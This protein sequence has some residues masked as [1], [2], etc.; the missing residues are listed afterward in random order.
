MDGEIQHL[1]N[2]FLGLGYPRFT[3][4]KALSLAKKRYY[5]PK[6][7]LEKDSQKPLVLPYMPN[8][9]KIKCEKIGL[10]IAFQF[11]N[12]IRKQITH[13]KNEEDNIG[14]GVYMIP[15]L[16][17]DKCYIGE[18]GRGLKVRCEEHVRACANG[19]PNSA[20]AQHSINLDHRINFKD[21]KII[22]REACSSKR[23]IVEGAAIHSVETFENNKAF[24]DEDDILSKI[25]FDPISKHFRAAISVA[26]P[27]LSL[28][29][30]RGVIV[31][32]QHPDAGTDGEHPN[33][34]SREDEPPPLRRSARIRSLRNLP[35]D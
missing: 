3:I 11:K 13:N 20:I 35:G 19:N 26:D 30:A 5:C 29:Q 15:C 32:E 22:Y 18:T 25:I 12:T 16:D 23:K 8:L 10:S 28:A 24:N 34:D 17:C 1:F 7:K 21:S 33:E 2:T 6:P 27:L 9:D 14:K 31:A 4:V